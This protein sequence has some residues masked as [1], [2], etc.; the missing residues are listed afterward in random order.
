M[1]A[2]TTILLQ[3][4]P[5][6]LIILLGFIAA[7]LLKAQKE[8][9][10]K[11][12]LYIIVPP[13]IFSGTYHADLNLALLSLPI[14]IFLIACTIS[15]LF[16]AIGK[17]VFKNDSTKNILA[18][19]AG[20]GNTGYFGVPVALII[21]GQESFSLIIMSILAFTFY[22]NTLGFFLTAKG[23]HTAKESLIKI[24]KLPSLYAFIFGL[25]LNYFQIPLTPILDTTIETVKNAYVPLGMMMLGMGLSS[26]GLKHLDFKF[27]GLT[28]LAKFLIWPAAIF[29]LIFLDQ[30][31]FHLYSQLIHNV[32]ILISII[33]LAVSTVIFA[34]ELKV[35]PDKAALAVLA[36]TLFS[37]FYIPL[38]VSLL[39]N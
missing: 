21:F 35:H 31:Y 29:G 25:I 17:A 22:E 28:F 16:F 32:L 14:V 11:L 37:L 39:I 26:V 13:V 33:P 7:R 10:A 30:N 2:F 27:F 18:Y 1:Q 6:Y 5:L 24:A 4:I 23:Q 9:V 38:I 20:T 8:T 19:T 34:T 15:L 36:S 3:L 12:L